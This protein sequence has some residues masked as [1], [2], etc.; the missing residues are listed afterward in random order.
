MVTSCLPSPRRVRKVFHENDVNTKRTRSLAT[1]ECVTLSVFS[2][3]HLFC[4]Q[5]MAEIIGLVSGGIAIAQ[6]TGKVGSLV[7]S[8]SRLWKEVKDVPETIKALV[9]QLKYFALSI[10]AIEAE[11]QAV[12]GGG[13]PPTPMC[14][15]AIQHC[16][17]L[18]EKLDKL[19]Q[20]LMGDI[21][22]TRRRKRYVAK[23]KAV[24]F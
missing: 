9:E 8:L 22:S 10:D 18:H 11:P 6:A 15:R 3:N 23:T 21:V 20:D 24:L 4:D 5:I 17:H 7:L 14:A 13:C 1:G 12:I 2:E 19:I 16:R